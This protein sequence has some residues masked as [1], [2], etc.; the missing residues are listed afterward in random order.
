MIGAGLV[1]LDYIGSGVDLRLHE[2]GDGGVGR[3][4]KNT[5][6]KEYDDQVEPPGI[7]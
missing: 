4:S 6:G 3:V 7:N 1:R 2:R 5:P